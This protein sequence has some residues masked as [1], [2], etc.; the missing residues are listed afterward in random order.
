VLELFNTLHSCDV[1]VGSRYVPGGGVDKDWAF[2]R[3][4]LSAFGNYYARTI[5]NLSI[6]DATGGFRLW[7]NKVLANLP[8]ERV[9]SNGYVF[10]VEMAYLA[11]KFG[12]RFKEIPIYFSERKWGKSKMSFRIQ[13]E[14]A[15][16]VWLLLWQYRDL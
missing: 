8:L 11:H 10:Q 2:W 14:A 1:A 7:H 9:R 4:G 5:L 3:K 15:I 16:R 12:Y 6:K 13:L